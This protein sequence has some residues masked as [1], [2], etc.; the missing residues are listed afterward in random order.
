MYC[1]KA[2][3]GST[4]CLET[5]FLPVNTSIGLYLDHVIE[6]L[7]GEPVNTPYQLTPRG[8]I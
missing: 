7:T 6:V 2:V 8:A 3:S 4:R 1:K 5:P